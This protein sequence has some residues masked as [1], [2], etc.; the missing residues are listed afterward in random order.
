M[1]ADSQR[2]GLCLLWAIAGGRISTRCGYERTTSISSN[3][4]SPDESASRQRPQTIATIVVD[5]VALE[6]SS[7]EHFY[8]YIDLVQSSLL[9]DRLHLSNFVCNPRSSV[10]L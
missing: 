9:R 10:S 2:S 5:F 6:C 3:F 7:V 8:H 1:H 4:R